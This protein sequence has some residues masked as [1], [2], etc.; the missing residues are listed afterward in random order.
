MYVNFLVFGSMVTKNVKSKID[1]SIYGEFGGPVV[2]IL[3]SRAKLGK[4]AFNANN[5][6]HLFCQTAAKGSQN[7]QKE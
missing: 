2:V 1:I 7:S 6:I 5:I 4:N 3:T